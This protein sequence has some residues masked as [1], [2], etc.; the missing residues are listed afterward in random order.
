MLR[1]I[2]PRGIDS[3]FPATKNHSK[4][5]EKVK[6]ECSS[7]FFFFWKMR[8]LNLIYV[9][10]SLQH[11]HTHALMYT[12]TQVNIYIGVYNIHVHMY[13]HMHRFWGG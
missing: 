11:T 12:Q 3:E 1:L 13:L 4:E 9:V 10:K 8:I 7:T 5:R 2:L 6:E